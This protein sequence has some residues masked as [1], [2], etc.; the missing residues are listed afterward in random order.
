M[1]LSDALEAF[2]PVAKVF[3]E[4]NVDY[5]LGGSV[6]S[7]IHGFPRGT[8]DIDVQADLQEKHVQPLVERLEADWMVTTAMVREALRYRTSFN[9][10]PIESIAKVDIFVPRK[11]PFD[12]S[13]MSRRQ[14]DIV[15]SDGTTI[16]YYVDSLE[17]AILR[18]IE[19]YQM[20]NRIADQKWLDVLAMIKAH[21]FDL[22]LDYLEHWAPN[23]GITDLLDKA[24]EESGFTE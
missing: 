15:M 11:T 2:D 7:S 9:I 1:D 6:A 16:P 17:D 10:I 4:L 14:K 18:K 20:G 24:L 23:L 5:Q 21:T 8:L 19:W 22:D 13:S 3:D 12:L